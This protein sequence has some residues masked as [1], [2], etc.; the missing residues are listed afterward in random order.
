MSHHVIEKMDCRA[1]VEKLPHLAEKMCTLWNTRDLET[2]VHSVLMDSRE[3]TRQGLPVEVAKE[4]M[5]VAELNSLVRAMETASR[6][7]MSLSEA[8][9]VIQEGDRS[10]QGLP[11]AG[12]DPWAEN[13]LTADMAGIR[14]A[15][16]KPAGS[17]AH[18]RPMPRSKSPMQDGPIQ[19]EE[20]KVAVNGK[21]AG[22][23]SSTQHYMS[24]FLNEAPPIPPLVR[25]D[26]TAPAAVHAAIA[27]SEGP[28]TMSSEFFRCI[29]REIRTLGVDELLLSHLGCAT[30]CP[31]IIDG[32]RFAKQHCRFPQVHLRVDPLN[33]SDQQLEDAIATG[34]DCL[35]IELNMACDNWR[36]RAEEQ[37]SQ[38][39][40]HFA[41]RLSQLLKKREEIYSRTLHRCII[42]VSQTG[43]TLP[44]GQLPQLVA[45]LAGMADSF[46]VDWLH[47]LPDPLAENAGKGGRPSGGC[48][49]WAPFIEA[50]V[51]PNGHL[52]VCSHDD[53]GDS[54]VADLKRTE[55]SDAWHAEEFRQTRLGLLNGTVKDTLCSACPRMVR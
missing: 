19:F 37:L 14:I 54:Y 30:Q 31:W 45:K 40:N 5:F 55:F 38:N 22:K 10:A 52:V 51:K 2:F 47:E 12:A 23:G 28:S 15:T 35:V 27:S 29:A 8:S 11:E 6:L 50:N 34:L 4:M 36:A 46:S 25:V 43:R 48:L 20:T 32:I 1:A 26:L 16:R 9:R 17:A 49:C 41:L 42:K 44:D 53:R 24:I 18:R 21:G 39:P 33:A 13:V 3:G 7:Q